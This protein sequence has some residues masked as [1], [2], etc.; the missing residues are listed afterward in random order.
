MF[1]SRASVRRP[2]AMSCFLIMLVLFGINS[3]DQ[4]G[5]DAFPNVEIPYVTVTTVYPGASRPRSRSMS[6]SASRTRSA[7]STDSRP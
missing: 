7:P 4:L 6:P 5:L 1:L 2:I 3:W